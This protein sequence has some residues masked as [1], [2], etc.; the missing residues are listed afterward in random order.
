MSYGQQVTQL[1]WVGDEMLVVAAEGLQG[2][3]ECNARLLG[4]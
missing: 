1:Q 2:K 3:F 4:S